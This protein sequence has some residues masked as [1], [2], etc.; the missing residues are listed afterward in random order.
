MTTH[1]HAQQST[2][3]TCL[4]RPPRRGRANRFAVASVRPMSSWAASENAPRVRT[5]G[6]AFVNSSSAR[7]GEPRSHTRQSA[8]TASSAKHRA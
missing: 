1:E 2:S 5:V 3:S 4:A 8:A 6:W 7:S